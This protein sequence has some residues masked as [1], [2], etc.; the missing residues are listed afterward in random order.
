MKNLTKN[1]WM[2]KI[3]LGLVTILTINFVTPNYTY[4][5][6][7]TDLGTDLLKE[8]VQLVGAIGDVVMGLL[9]KFMLGTTDFSSAMLSKSD[10]NL[11]SEDSWLYADPSEFNASQPGNILINVDELNEKGLFDVTDWSIPNMLYSPE[12]IFSNRIAML[13]INFI[14]PSHYSSAVTTND[15]PESIATQLRPTIAKWYNGFR[16]IAIVVLLSVLVYLGIRII[17]SSTAVDKAKYKESIKSWFIALVLVFTMQFIMAGTLMLIDQFTNLFSQDID[18]GILIQ[19]NGEAQPGTS[20]GD[21]TFRTNLMGLVRFMAQSNTWQDVT[22][23]TIMYLALIIY[24]IIF[25]FQYLKRVLWMAFLTMISPLVAMTYPIDKI[26]DG[27]SQAFNLWFKEYLM[28]AIIQ[29][30]HLLLYT[31]LLGSSIDLAAEN[32]LYAIVALLFLVPAEKFI[33]KLFGLSSDTSEGFGSFAGGALTMS[34]LQALSK[35]RIHKPVKGKGNDDKDSDSSDNGKIKMKQEGIS[36]F[37]GAGLTGT[38]EVAGAGT[39]GAGGAAAGG[40][41]AGLAGVAGPLAIAAGAAGAANAVGNAASSAIDAAGRAINPGIGT[42]SENTNVNEGEGSGMPWGSMIDGNRLH[43]LTPPADSSLDDNDYTEAMDAYSYNPYAS[44]YTDSSDDDNFDEAMEAYSYYPH[45][46]GNSEAD[47]GLLGDYSDDNNWV[48][49]GVVDMPDGTDLGDLQD[50]DSMTTRT[51]PGTEPNPEQPESPPPPEEPT[52]RRKIAGVASATASMARRKHAGRY[53]GNIAKRLARG[54]LR[55]AGSG[56]GAVIGLSA[57]V[58]TGDFS[59][60]AQYMATGAVAGGMIGGNV[61][62]AGAML[63]GGAVDLAK[64]INN[65]DGRFTYDYLAATRG[66]EYAENWRKQQEEGKQRNKFMDNDDNLYKYRQMAARI[67]EQSRKAGINKQYSAQELMNHAFEY[68]RRGFNDDDIEKGLAMEALHGGITSEN[69]DDMM[70][71][72]NLKNKYGSDYITDEKKAQQFDKILDAQ[73]GSNQQAKN[74]VKELFAESHGLKGY[75]LIQG[76]QQ[77]R[78]QVNNERGVR[79]EGGGGNPNNVV[80]AGNRPSGNTP[81]PNNGVNNS[82]GNNSGTSQ[83]TRGRGTT[84]NQRRNNAQ[85]RNTSS[86]SSTG[87]DDNDFTEAMDA[88][89]RRN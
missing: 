78:Q 24:T 87:S 20:G 42:V 48:Q 38:T 44:G 10:I 37:G 60:M 55:V 77:G 34:A 23:Y 2:Q 41:A 86:E 49:S 71:I 51:F 40:A 81:R 21:L 11:Y 9:N 36:S 68:S 5:G 84:N 29:P 27:R 80:N 54:T 70:R 4:A 79:P 52:L 3:I 61:Y 72:M 14:S 83:G 46:R 50:I 63:G 74:Q 35:D 57:G 64:S 65:S 67:N 82:A 58:T 73:L 59:K 62:K 88:Y 32:Q 76:G 31:A 13:D 15:D 6:F 18:D 17:I 26:A 8:V 1:K 22:A 69:T 75:H 19:V 30:V 43:S 45:M 28:N 85:R 16:N 7:W 12:Y 39:A 56:M 25:T 33:K 53:V 47:T 89:T 66:E